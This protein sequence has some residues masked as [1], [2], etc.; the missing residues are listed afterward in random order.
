MT[1]CV[2]CSGGER[3]ATKANLHSLTDVGV[4][5]CV[6]EHL[7]DAQSAGVK[8]RLECEDADDPV[9]RRGSTVLPSSEII[10]PYLV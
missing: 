8:L 6:T 9:G 5:R 1:C 10:G 2:D 4:T 7:D 3:R